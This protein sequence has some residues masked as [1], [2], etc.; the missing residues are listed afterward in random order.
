MAIERG[1]M[2]GGKVI[3]GTDFVIRDWPRAQ[4]D[5]PDTLKRRSRVVNLIVWHWTGGHQ[6]VGPNAAAKAVRNCE[7]RTRPDGT[8]ADVGYHFLVCVD[9]MVWQ[10]A[11]LALATWHVGDRFTVHRSIGIEHAYPGTLT[12]SRRLGV[13]SLGS[14]TISIDGDLVTVTIPPIE[15]MRASALLADALAGIS[16][17]HGF[18]IPKRV[19]IEGPRSTPFRSRRFTPIEL[20]A[21]TGGMEHYAIEPTAANRKAGR[22]KFDGA[23]L[24]LE[25][26]LGAGWKG[27]AP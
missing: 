13:E 18:E 19:P 22:V 25:N 9:G 1:I 14:R 2:V 11:D 20:R 27:A 24:F 26:A 16:P 17:S 21:W 23:G 4:F 12:Q 7:A 3:P 6:F 15:M 8:L 10:T 5:P